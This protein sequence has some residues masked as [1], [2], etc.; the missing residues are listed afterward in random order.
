MMDE[1]KFENLFELGIS[2]GCGEGASQTG[3][4]SGRLDA[5][6]AGIVEVAA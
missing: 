5:A 6:M 4:D 2:I 3:M 1:M